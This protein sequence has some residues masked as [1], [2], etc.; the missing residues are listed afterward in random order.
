LK[1][2]DLATGLALLDA[3]RLGQFAPA[4]DALP[5]WSVTRC[6]PTGT[7]FSVQATRQQ[8]SKITRSSSGFFL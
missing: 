5:G 3:Q 2:L 4:D 8:S 1:A 7:T 6:R